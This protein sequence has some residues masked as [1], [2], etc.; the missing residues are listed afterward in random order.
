MTDLEMG[1]KAL[2]DAVPDYERAGRYFEGRPSEWFSTAKLERMLRRS[3]T[4]TLRLNF[5]Q[6]AVLAVSD[7]LEL[8]SVV[9]TDDAAQELLDT[10]W[11][12]N[13]LDVELPNAFLRAGEFGDAY[14]LL[15]V[16]EDDSGQPVVEVFYNSPLVGRM[17]YQQDNPR[18][19]WFYVKRWQTT[20][21]NTRLAAV[22]L[23][24][25]YADRTE[26][27]STKTPDAK[28]VTADEFTPYTGPDDEDGDHIID[29]PLGFLPVY[30]LRA[31]GRPY[32]TP[33]H[34]NA[35]GPQDAINK[36]AITHLGG[37]DFLS[38][39]QRYALEQTDTDVGEDDIDGIYRAEQMASLIEGTPGAEVPD[40]T[41]RPH[42]GL[43]SDPG[44]VW[45]LKNVAQVGQFTPA[46]SSNFLDSIVLYI[47]IMAHVTTTPT[48]LFDLPG[49]VPSGES[50]RAADAPLAK[51]AAKRMLTYGGPVRDCLED[52]LRVLGVT[53]PNVSLNWASSQIV[54]D[55]AGWTVA[56][57][58]LTAGVPLRQVLMDQGYTTTQLDGWGVPD[59][60][61]S[62]DATLTRQATMLQEIGKGIQ[63]LAAGVSLGVISQDQVDTIIESI[64]TR[65]Q[66]AGDVATEEA[67][68]Q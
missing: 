59:S 13:E 37:I 35:Y 27:Y 8:T 48:Y 2:L 1:L 15:D 16:D 26:R 5:A 60:V 62:T 31:G 36:L 10:V 9:A 50:Q 51:K 25:L 44:G 42:N 12:D 28:G 32:G 43:T 29:N 58:K 40:W 56:Q 46:D 61:Y 11:D 66:M 23:S 53:N 65:A 33:E 30:H 45:W 64:L 57:A 4:D 67:A 54:D 3:R 47:K 68:S 39:P 34:V 41:H 17:I 14:L 21:P 38:F 6:T 7:R 22:R 63:G 52:A 19:K 20:D 49:E 18:K 55:N 24:L